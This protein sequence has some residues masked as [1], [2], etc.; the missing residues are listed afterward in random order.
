MLLL[1]DFIVVVSI[2]S[3][4]I[5]TIIYSTT[6]IPTTS[7]KKCY[8][9]NTV[10]TISILFLMAYLAA[11]HQ[12]IQKIPHN[13]N[14][15][16]APCNN[17]NNLMDKR[18]AISLPIRTKNDTTT[19]E[20]TNQKSS[21]SIQPIH[22]DIPSTTVSEEQHQ[23]QQ[24][25]CA[26]AIQHFYDLLHSYRQHPSTAAA[27]VYH[28]AEHQKSGFGR[29]LQVSVKACHLALALGRPCVVNWDCRD[30]SFTW[31][32]FLTT[33]KYDWEHMR[34]VTEDIE[35]DV[36]NIMA[37]NSR[38][39][40]TSIFDN[41]TVVP[42]HVLPMFK[43]EKWDEAYAD[44]S[45]E[46]STIRKQVLLTPNY[47]L[48]WFP[49]LSVPV[50]P[51]N[52]NAKDSSSCSTEQL[53]T[54]LQEAMYQPTILTQRLHE[55]RRQT[56]IGANI[57]STKTE[58][59]SIHLRTLIHDWRKMHLTVEEYTDVIADCIDDFPEIATWWLIS[60]NV[61]LAEHITQALST[62]KLVTSY[63]QEFQQANHHSAKTRKAFQQ[64]TMAPSVLD[65]MVL[66]DSKVALITDGSFGDT[67]GR[68][69]GK[70]FRRKCKGKGKAKKRLRVYR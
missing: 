59:G 48:A 8:K 51:Y 21:N 10:T 19:S 16:N 22:D 58:Y 53:W 2:A 17:N 7:V 61:T 20:T 43:K 62:K 36:M 64:E 46:N 3:R 31:R 45:S 35:T 54:A 70:Y 56:F 65:W 50:S 29:P 12:T 24:K 38:G 34:S 60:D 42:P 37:T 13:I 55:E 14:D 6:M 1:S 41:D 23:Q 15:N 67:G 66:Y 25:P 28:Y 33:G 57:N 68:G 11:F 52:T 40:G 44:W 4:P 63:T 39:K 47:G 69:N 27:P 30:E 49:H 18:R 9:L 26:S 5:N 32:T